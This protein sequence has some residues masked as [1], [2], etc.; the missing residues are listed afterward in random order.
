[1]VTVVMMVLPAL[2]VDTLCSSGGMIRTA[3]NTM[4]P[5]GANVGE[6]KR[7]VPEKRLKTEVRGW[8]PKEERM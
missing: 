6:N 1:M 5:L 7:I 8:V 2:E 4:I 3:E